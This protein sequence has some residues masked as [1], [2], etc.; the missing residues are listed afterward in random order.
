MKIR[1][2]VP[3]LFLFWQCASPPQAPIREAFDDDD[4]RLV[5]RADFAASGWHAVPAAASWQA[6][7]SGV[8]LKLTDGREAALTFPAADVVRWWVSPA[9][10]EQP[11][12]PAARYPERGPAVTVQE[13]GGTLS[14]DTPSLSVRLKLADLSWTLVRGDAVVLHTAGGPRS[15][16]RRLLQAFAAS[17][18]TWFGPGLET[19]SSAKFWISNDPDTVGP[20]AA[21]ALFG[22][23]A[24][25]FAVVLDNS[26]Q[27]YS[28]VSAGEASLGALNGGLDLL[29]AAAPDPEAVVTAL[30]ALTGRPPALPAWALATSV[31][32][33]AGET[34]AFLRQAKLAIGT[35]S[36]A[37][38]DRQ[39]L[40]FHQIVSGPSTPSVDPTDATAGKAWAVWAV[41]G[42]GSSLAP[43][44]GSTA[45]NVRFDDDGRHSPLA[46]MNNLVPTWEARTVAE[47][48]TVPV[49]VTT[50]SAGPG[51]VRWALAELTSRDTVARAL[52]L[53]LAGYGIPAARVD[54]T[55]LAAADT[56]E[57]AFHTLL[58]WLMA[59]VLTLDWGP[60]P[61]GFWTALSDTDKKRLKTILDLRSQFQPTLAQAARRAA[62]GVPAWRPVW[63]ANTRD[64]HAVV[65]DEF[66]LGDLLVAPVP[67]GSSKRSVYL[68]GPGVWFDFWTDEEYGGGR[69]YDVDFKNDRPPLFVRG[70][71]FVPMRDAEIYDRRDIANPIAMHVF[72][73]GRGQGTYYYDDG[74]SAGKP[75]TFFETRLVYDYSQR[76][77]TL[78]HQSVTLGALHPELYMLYRLHNVYRPKQVTIDGKPVPLY[79]PS[80]GITD[81]DRSAAWYEDDRSLLI[82]TFR[83]EKNQVILMSF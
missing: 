25:P 59:P 16:G 56:K 11:L 66:L 48:A 45:W 10:G 36:G 32:L 73:G 69:S 67:A 40:Q 39:A 38:A 29:V 12:S 41:P 54:L 68:P 55:G 4:H 65:S 46:R 33:P 28:R 2:L 80:W 7:P 74:V 47:T 52:T 77:M 78:E 42:T 62:T 70:G 21:P 81:S 61:A 30:T 15:A 9:P 64:A 37:A 43:Y 8:T 1:W 17:D 58:T 34:G 51:T 14:L 44:A 31:S 49:P 19:D 60:D 57:A 18:A 75:G 76:D 63:F 50:S 82:K 5:S 6:T 83:P 24:V 20:W 23:G 71:A 35:A 13:T 27:T 79:G 53:G 3:A 26:Y 72:P 22:L